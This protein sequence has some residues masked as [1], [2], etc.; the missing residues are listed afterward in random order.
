MASSSKDLRFNEESYV[1]LGKL[2]M[3]AHRAEQEAKI[4]AGHMMTLQDMS[5]LDKSSNALLKFRSKAEDL[6]ARNGMARNC[7]PTF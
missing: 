2:L 1:K 7:V 5:N 6:M 4:L 3:L